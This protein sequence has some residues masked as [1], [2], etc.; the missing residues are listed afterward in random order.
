MLFIPRQ[1]EVV[2]TGDMPMPWPRAAQFRPRRCLASRMAV[3]I[4]CLSMVKLLHR[5]QW[6]NPGRFRL[7]QGGIDLRRKTAAIGV[8]LPLQL[9]GAGHQKIHQMIADA[10]VGRVVNDLVTLARP[11]YVD[12]YRLSNPR[13]GA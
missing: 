10:V 3:R 2:H 6:Y 1:A 5:G 4:C 13:L 7:V 8:Y 11:R 12:L 9:G